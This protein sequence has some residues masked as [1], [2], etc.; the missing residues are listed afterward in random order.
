MLITRGDV[1]VVP[2]G[3]TVLEVGDRLLVFAEKYD[4]PTV[5]SILG[6]RK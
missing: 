4:L 2:R 5:R 3:S 6:A 1:S